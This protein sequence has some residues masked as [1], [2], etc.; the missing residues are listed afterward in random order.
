MAL[1]NNT[2]DGVETTNNSTN[3][4]GEQS[5]DTNTLNSGMTQ[6]EIDDANKISVTI[7]DQNTP[8]VV[9][10][11]P[12]ACGK[13]MA[14]VRLSR[15]LKQNGYTIEPVPSFRPT[16]DKNYNDMCDNFDNI[17]DSENAALSTKNINFMLILVSHNGRPICQILEGPGEYYFNPE[18]PNAPF[19]KYINAIINSNNR[20][21]WAIMVEPHRTNKRMG[22]EQRRD[23][24]AKISKLKSR[25]SNR[26]RTIFVYNKIDQTNFVDSPGHIRYKHAIQDIMNLYPN[27]FVPFLNVNPITK[28]WRP[29][30]F[31]FIAF[32]TG[33]YSEAADGTFVF[34]PGHDVYPHKLWE[35]IR[36]RVRG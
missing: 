29:Y 26:D 30:N 31:D 19:P 6:I 8:L 14:L 12:P 33:D 1:F 11:G 35:L 5:I 2:T 24:V 20:K 7:A 16:Y 27:I 18:N 15:F 36:K 17:I 9:L 4:I 25:L 23:Y 3:T 21:I 32:H 10:F 34:Q 22:V 28:L 13:T